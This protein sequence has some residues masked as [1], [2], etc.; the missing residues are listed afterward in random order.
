MTDLDKMGLEEVLPAEDDALPPP[1]DSG[2][3]T[4]FATE[5]T[6]LRYHDE[7]KRA[8][9][10][11][12]ARIR[13]LEED[14][15]SYR[16]RTEEKFVNISDDLKEIK[17]SI[18]SIRPEPLKIRTV[19]VGT[20]PLLVL[21]GTMIW[22]A[23]QYPDRSE[24]ESLRAAVVTASQAASINASWLNDMRTRIHELEVKRGVAP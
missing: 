20:L 19:F 11:F 12:E 21:L 17:A 13:S 15:A 18:V 14:K 16:A 23:G 7:N 6:V 5:D 8:H 1:D 9:F 10:E 22:R 3:Y 4:M 2:K 24:F